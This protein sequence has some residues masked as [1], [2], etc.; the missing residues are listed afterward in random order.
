M[1]TKDVNITPG[2]KMNIVLDGT[3]MLDEVITVAYGTAKRSSFTGSASVL[4][5]SEIEQVQVTNPVDALKGKVSGVQ[6]NSNSGAPGNSSPSVLIRGISSINAGTSPLIVLDGT[7]YDGGL[8][9]IST[10]DIESMTV[11]KDAASNALYGARGA[12]GVILITTK[13]GKQGNARVTLDAKWGQNSRAVQ[14]YDVITSPLSIT[15]HS[16]VQSAT[17]Q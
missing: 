6:I 16:A 15:R 3:N 4:D 9:N 10:Q 11:L 8:D 12:N 5:A 1:T 7:P 14:D 2:Q 17:M 13:R